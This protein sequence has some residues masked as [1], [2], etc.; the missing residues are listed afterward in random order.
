MTTSFRR[1]LMKSKVERSQETAKQQLHILLDEATVP[2]AIRDRVTP[3][4]LDELIAIGFKHQ[5]DR[6]TRDA[7]GEVRAAVRGALM[8]G[9]A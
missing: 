6:D 1:A 2:D 5:F 4:L 8:A 3:A 7:L 9:G